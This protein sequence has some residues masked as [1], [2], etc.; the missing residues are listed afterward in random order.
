MSD[1][2]RVKE[3]L[4]IVDIVSGYVELKNAGSNYKGVCPFHNEKTPSFMVNPNLQIYKCF[5]CGKGGDVFNFLM[6]IERLDFSE[7]L[8]KAA[9]IAGIE[10]KDLPSKKI[11]KEEEKKKERIL[12]ANNLASKYYNHILKTHKAGKPGRDYAA[13]RNIGANEIELFRVGFAP[14]N[15]TNLK[16][17]LNGRGFSDEELVEFGLVVDRDGNMIDKFRNRLMQTIFDENGEVVGFSG[18]YIEKSE[19]APKYLNTSETLV[20]KKQNIMYGLFQGKDQIR[21]DKFVIIVE[22]NIDP[23][24]A[25]RVGTGNIVAPLGTAFTTGQAKKLK[26]FTDTIY[27]CFDTD[28]AGLNAL[29]RSIPIA[30]ETGLSHKVIDITGF[31]DADELINKDEKKWKELVSNPV[32]TIMFLKSKFSKQLDLGTAEGK[33]N[34]QKR[35]IPII[36]SIKDETIRNHYIKD[37]SVLLEITRDELKEAVKNN[38]VAIPKARVDINEKEEIPVKKTGLSQEEYMLAIILQNNLNDFF[39]TIPDDFFINTEL[40]NEVLKIVES[41]E[42]IENMIKL[43]DSK[44]IREELEKIMLIDLSEVED[45]DKTLDELYIRLYKNYLTRKILEVRK[46]IASD[47][48]S[49]ESI[50]ELNTLTSEL[51]T[52][53]GVTFVG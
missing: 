46:K 20:Y 45:L 27:F 28:E 49:E 22:G 18:R 53:E 2:E 5:G 15:K 52:L 47:N 42:S 3:A 50:A 23:I 51:R 4:N 35:M 41:E 44:D 6:E 36:Q 8:K 10:L 21:K 12:E 9:E 33:K 19:Y 31:Q 14:N 48:D 40:Y 16:S 43:I 24:S 34:F 37:I 1:I 32:D 11:N 17:F 29:I 39:L 25:H 26:R 13:K 7:A 30:E 38:K